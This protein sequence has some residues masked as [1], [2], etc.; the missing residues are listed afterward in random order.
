[1]M[2]IA[3]IVL[4]TIKGVRCVQVAKSGQPMDWNT[5]TSSAPMMTSCV[6][7][8]RTCSAIHAGAA[9]ASSSMN[10]TTSP[11]ASSAPRVR[12]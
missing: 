9:T 7:Y 10:A 8:T 3:P 12:L 5:S 1:M 6:C 2:A 4:T 11:V